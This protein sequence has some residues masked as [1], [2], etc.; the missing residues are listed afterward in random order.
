LNAGFI[1]VKIRSSCWLSLSHK[2]LVLS[3]VRKEVLTVSSV[4][5]CVCVCVCVLV[6][7]SVTKPQFIPTSITISGKGS[8]T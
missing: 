6:A 3:A 5:V 4:C 1:A 7:V 8:L 2:K